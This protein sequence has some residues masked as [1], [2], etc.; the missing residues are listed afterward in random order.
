MAQGFA[1]GS[2]IKEPY[3]FA[4]HGFFIATSSND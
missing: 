3:L 1:V 2:K 4:L